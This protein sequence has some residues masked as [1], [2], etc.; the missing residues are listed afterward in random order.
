MT[1]NAT[2]RRRLRTPGNLGMRGVLATL[3]M[4]ALAVVVSAVP[5]QADQSDHL[6]SLFSGPFSGIGVLGSDPACPF[7][8][9]THYEAY[10]A[11]RPPPAS[12]TTELVACV[13]VRTV[14]WSGRGTFTVTTRTG[15][16]LFGTVLESSAYPAGAFENTLGVTGGTRQFRNVRGTI[17]VTGVVDRTVGS[18]AG[19]YTASLRKA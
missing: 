12:G 3:A 5:A 10:G 15:A 7:V 11:G 14:P 8:H 13:D 19:T 17:V 2:L 1:T 4:V 9:V 16:T 18:I 6:N